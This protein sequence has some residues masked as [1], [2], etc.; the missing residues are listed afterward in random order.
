MS[1][2]EYPVSFYI[3][4]KGNVY[5]HR[6]LHNCAWRECV[7]LA[8]YRHL[9][10]V[11]DIA[12]LTP[13]V[14]NCVSHRLNEMDK[15]LNCRFLSLG[16]TWL[17][18]TERWKWRPRSS[19]ETELRPPIDAEKCL[20]TSYCMPHLRL[21]TLLVIMWSSCVCTGSSWCSRACRTKWKTWQEGEWTQWPAVCVWL[22][23]LSCL[24]VHCLRIYLSC[25]WDLRSC[26]FFPILHTMPWYALKRPPIPGSMAE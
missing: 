16:S 14:A 2:Y 20:L 3:C 18:W 21:E 9:L 13:H 22:Y 11:L 24:C 10:F 7:Y 23:V 5:M 25:V 15:C 8:K 17:S 26:F 6:T 12:F 19:G 4:N 1:W